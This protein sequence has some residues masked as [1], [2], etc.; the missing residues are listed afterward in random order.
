[1]LSRVF[2][3]I[4]DMAIAAA[5]GA[6]GMADVFFVAFK[7]P[8]LFRRLFAEGAFNLAFV[9]LF[10]DKL[11]RD[12]KEA[13]RSFASEALSALLLVLLLVVML[14]EITMPGVIALFAPGFLDEPDRF[15]AAVDLA[16]VTFPYLLFI[17]LVSLLSG[18]LNSVGRFWAAAAA[19]ILLNLTLIFAV[20]IAAPYF[21]TPAHALSWGVFAAGILQ[22]LWLVWHAKRAGWA[23]QLGRPKFSADVKKL[24]K[25]IAPVAVGAGIYQINLL[26]DTIIASLLPV[27]TISYLFYADRLH[28][29]PV[30]VIGVAVGTALLP[31][32]S[33]QISA[34]EDKA[35][36]AGQNRALE[37][38]LL[39]TLPAA[40]ALI[41]MPETILQ[42]LF[43]RGA[44]THDATIKTAQ[45]LAMFSVGLPAYIIIK[46]IAPGFFS[47]GDTATPIKIG[48]L[49]LVINLVLNLLLMKPFA[50][51]GIAAAT[52][53]ASWVNAGLLTWV[54]MGR[55]HFSFDGRIKKNVPRQI[56]ATVVM[57]GV[58]W[59]LIGFLADMFTGP[60]MGQVGA[61]VIVV[62][63]GMAVYGAMVLALGVVK[64]SELRLMFKKTAKLD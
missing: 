36:L 6:G 44:F 45:A 35:A 64:I 21:E 28:Q 33:R 34:G 57:A 26:V 13:A 37:F 52:V 56:L 8:N 58:I 14:F 32:L 3:F 17:A 49:C 23:L 15:N 31:L 41:I 29:L 19:P 47:R 22:L 61:L 12:G 63:A 54:L 55:G 9:P 7:L 43:E 5:L 59:G 16:R 10:S 4:R 18:V 1:M 20:V 25:R 60:I 30:G 50:H 48:V 51:V 27:G 39:L 24:L 46:A 38:A 2:G 11:E 42:V 40:A 53:T 62:A